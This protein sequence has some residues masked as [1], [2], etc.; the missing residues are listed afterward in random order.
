MEFQPIKISRNNSFWIKKMEANEIFMTIL[1]VYKSF[2]GSAPSAVD[3]S[4]AKIRP[5]NAKMESETKKV[6]TDLSNK[7]RQVLQ[8]IKDSSLSPLQI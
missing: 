5:R 6:W 4:V 3:T 2:I 1:Q 7:A 8:P